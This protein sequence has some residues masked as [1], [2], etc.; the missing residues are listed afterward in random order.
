MLIRAGL[1]IR[2]R[3]MM[4]GEFLGRVDE[5]VANGWQF[6]ECRVDCG[7]VGSGWAAGAAEEAGGGQAWASHVADPGAGEDVR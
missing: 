5:M 7:H 3:R 4:I 6:E 1:R 2:F